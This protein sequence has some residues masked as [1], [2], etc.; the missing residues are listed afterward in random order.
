MS[1]PNIAKPPSAPPSSPSPTTAPVLHRV[2]VAAIF[3]FDTICT[4]AVWAIVYLELVQSPCESDH[5][6][7]QSTLQTISVIL[8]ATYT[9]ASIEQLFLCFLYF[10][11]TNKRIITTFLVLC[12]AVHLG[13][14]YASAI[15]ILVNNT[16]IGSSIMASRVGSILCAATDVMIAAALVF[17]FVRFERTI[18]IRVS[19]QSLL[20]R[21]MVLIFTSG[22][23]VASTTLLQMIFLLR[24]ISA[25][26]L[27]FYCQGRIYALT[28]LCNFL[29]GIPVQPALETPGSIVTGAIFHNDYINRTIS[30]NFNPRRQSQL[31]DTNLDQLDFPAGKS[32]VHSD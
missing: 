20:R 9:T 5:V 17:T 4:F 8:V 19:M 3:A 32:Q 16:P 13:F 11:L 7:F 18:V 2:G 21:L 28:I 27:F 12:I 29:V 10:S 26:S 25:Y 6:F 31:T 1:M 30:G 14:A 15:L 24:D 23:V 22:V